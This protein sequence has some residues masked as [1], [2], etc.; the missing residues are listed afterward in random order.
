MNTVVRVYVN[1]V[2]V[3]VP[4]DSPVL[5]AVVKAGFRVPLL[6]YLQGLFNEATCRICV[7]KANG[8]IVPACR[9]PVQE[10]MQVV[11]ED[12]ELKTMRRVNLELLLATHRISC[13]SCSM[14]GSCTLLTLA[15]ELGVEG[16]PVCA[17][18]PLYGELCLLR[19]GVVC[20]GPLTVAGCNAECTR[21]GVPCLGCRGFIQSTD[22]WK[23]ALKYYRELGVEPEKLSKL[24]EIFWAR[25]PTR[26]AELLER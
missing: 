10:N 19:R 15:K 21:L 22:T 9:Y 14:K 18:C 24:M 17:E 4:R 1:G 12:N 11:T 20:L 23:E 6:C 25:L 13:W 3:D 26:L 8:R 2:E 16:I 7:V 5:H